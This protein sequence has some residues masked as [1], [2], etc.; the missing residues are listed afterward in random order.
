MPKTGCTNEVITFINNSKQATKWLWD[1]DDGTSSTEQQPAGKIFS[2]LTVNKNYQITLIASNNNCADTLSKA[3]TIM[4]NC[5]ILI[6]NI[7]T[8]N[9]DGLNDYLYPL[10]L[11]N[12]YIFDF[13]VFDRYGKLLFQ[14]NKNQIKWDGTYHGK[15]LPAGTYTWY[16]KYSHN[17][18]G[19]SGQLKG[20]SLLIR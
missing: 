7:F 19:K 15:K 18:A 13:K 14:S 17:A 3:I 1:F 4:A 8:P 6:P 10:N 12:D 2:P 9:G 5:S 11:S 16:L 20:T